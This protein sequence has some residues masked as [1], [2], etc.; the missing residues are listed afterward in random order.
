VRR[1]T[2]P[3]W[4]EFVREVAKLGAL[5]KTKNKILKPVPFSPLQ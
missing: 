5:K 1:C 3:G 4:Q 2:P